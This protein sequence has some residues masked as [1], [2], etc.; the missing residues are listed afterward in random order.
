VIVFQHASE[1][2]HLHYINNKI[3]I[4][5][6]V[7]PV[8]RGHNYVPEAL[9]INYDLLKLIQEKTEKC[10]TM[11]TATNFNSK[12]KHDIPLTLSKAENYLNEKKQ[13]KVNTK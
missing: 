11:S 7:K 8:F 3:N 13:K 4:P 5:A 10:E 1:H 9:S 12:T 6:P 2:L